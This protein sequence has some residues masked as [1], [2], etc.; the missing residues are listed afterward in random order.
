M[1]Q[2]NQAAALPLRSNRNAQEIFNPPFLEMP[3]QNAALAKPGREIRAAVAAMA[4]EYEVR[5][6]RQNLEAQLGEGAD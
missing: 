6:G 5:R 1:Q 3:Y 2:S 4:R